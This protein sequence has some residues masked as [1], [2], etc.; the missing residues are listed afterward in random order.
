MRY[1]SIA[2][3]RGFELGRTN[4]TFKIQG[5]EHKTSCL[6]H[7]VTDQIYSYKLE[8]VKWIT[9]QLHLLNVQLCIMKFYT[10]LSLQQGLTRIQTTPPFFHLKNS[11]QVLLASL[12][13]HINMYLLWK[14]SSLSGKLV[15]ALLEY[16]N[17]LPYTQ[18]IVVDLISWFSL[19]T[20]IHKKKN[21][22]IHE[23]YYTARKVV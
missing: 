13:L 17:V 20:K 3:Y 12:L 8:E 15:S 2:I 23:I 14:K 5:T 10:L 19:M 18:K 6:E 11:K 21:A 1:G 7:T 4:Y 16:I 9:I 22:T